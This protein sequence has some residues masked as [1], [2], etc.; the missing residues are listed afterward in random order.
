MVAIYSLND[1]KSG[2]CT[3]NCKTNTKSQ[4]KS[5][6]DYKAIQIDQK[7]WL[8]LYIKINSRSS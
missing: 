6:N 3:K 4:I 2:V 7:T 1:K 8:K 5:R